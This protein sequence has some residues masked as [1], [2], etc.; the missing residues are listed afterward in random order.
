MDPNYL[1]EF[2]PNRNNRCKSSVNGR[3]CYMSEQYIAHAR[4]A[5]A[6]A[7]RTEGIAGSFQEFQ[8]LINDSTCDIDVCAPNTGV[9]SEEMRQFVEDAIREKLESL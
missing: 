2:N 3:I 1:H 8:V 7:K 9:P 5:A 6:E 4:Y